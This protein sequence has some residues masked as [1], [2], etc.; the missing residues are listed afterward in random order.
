MPI[1]IPNAGV[2][3]TRRPLTAATATPIALNAISNPPYCR[4]EGIGP[5]PEPNDPPR[6]SEAGSIVLV[7]SPGP[8]ILLNGV[9]A[10]RTSLVRHRPPMSCYLLKRKRLRSL[11]WFTL[12]LFDRGAP[13]RRTAVLSLHQDIQSRMGTL[14]ASNFG[15]AGRLGFGGGTTMVSMRRAVRSLSPALAATRWRCCGRNFMN[16]LVCWLVTCRPS[17]SALVVVVENRYGPHARG[18][19]TQ[20]NAHVAGWTDLRSS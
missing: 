1:I 13:R 3:P 7:A 4:G 11:L 2:T 20:A 5:V 8:T 10:H 16:N 12:S 14:H 19:Q 9:W 17:T 6:S 18:P 15:G